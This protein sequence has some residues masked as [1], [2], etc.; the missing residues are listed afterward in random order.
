M[1]DDE[2]KAQAVRCVEAAYENE[3]SEMRGAARTIVGLAFVCALLSAVLIAI[4]TGSLPVALVLAGAGFLFAVAFVVITR[5]V[6]NAARVP[7]E[8]HPVILAIE[9]RPAA[10]ATISDV[11]V[12]QRRRPAVKVDF[13]GGR[14]E[15]L[16]APEEEHAELLRALLDVTK[17]T[18]PATDIAPNDVEALFAPRRARRRSVGLIAATPFA[19]LLVTLGVQYQ[20]AS[21]EAEECEAL[22]R[23]LV[24]E[25]DAA[26]RR[27][28]A[29]IDASVAWPAAP[30]VDSLDACP[31]LSNPLVYEHT[32]TA[33]FPVVGHAYVENV[34]F[35]GRAP[36]FGLHHGFDYFVV[37]GQSPWRARLT[38]WLEHLDDPRPLVE[39][40]SSTYHET[41]DG[42]FAQDFLVRVLDLE[43]HRVTCVAR[44]AN[45]AASFGGLDSAREARIS[46][47]RWR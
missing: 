30:E 18:D 33:D 25:T 2:T 45:E 4:N 6:R 13:V 12:G 29:A 40:R 42:R 3:A 16:S 23:R 10:I 17:D 46:G 26:K 32:P 44:F 34:D 15:T 7:V 27:D 41:G 24:R 22:V 8:Q 21:L 31:L 35:S 47:R 9:T 39:V 11:V 19:L 38:R 20:L 5:V 36:E 37:Y 1:S 14:S 43:A 28:A